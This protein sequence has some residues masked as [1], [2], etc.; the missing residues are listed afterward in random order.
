MQFIITSHVAA[1]VP[2]DM[3]IRLSGMALQINIDKFN[4]KQNECHPPEQ[5]HVTFRFA[6]VRG[7]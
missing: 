1:F 2:F 4:A 3:L 5:T 7:R 6:L